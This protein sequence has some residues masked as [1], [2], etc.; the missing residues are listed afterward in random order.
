MEAS[1]AAL[2]LPTPSLLTPSSTQSP[3][4]ERVDT[5]SLLLLFDEIWMK[6]M[7]LAKKLRDIMR[8]Y[9]EVR[10]RLN[11]GLQVNVL[12]T[13]MKT[14]DQAFK[15][16]MITAGGAMLSGVLTIG[17]GAAGG[18]TGL[19]AGQAIGHAAGGV[20]GLGAGVAQRQSDQDKAIADLQQNGA[21]SYNKSLMDILD[22]ATEIMQQ[23]MSVGSSLVEVLAQ[24]LQALTR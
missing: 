23:I 24:I 14:I 4:G 9:N 1:N 19:I 8:A 21:Q 5:D 3:S 20:M 15:A 6:L 22:K 13:Q 7:E 16:S 18:E 11:W 12:Q 17:F 10:Q 2:V